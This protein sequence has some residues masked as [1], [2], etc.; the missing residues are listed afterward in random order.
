MVGHKERGARGRA[1]QPWRLGEAA[2]QSG[3]RAAPEEGDD[4]WGPPVSR[5]WRG[6]KAAQGEAFSREGGSNQ[7]G[8]HRRV[9]GWAERAS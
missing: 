2:A 5:A 3:A 7:A 9:V 4:R 8:R 6:V 1:R